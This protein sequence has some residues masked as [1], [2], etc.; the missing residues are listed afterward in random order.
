MG[1][2]KSKPTNSADN[3]DGHHHDNEDAQTTEMMN[4]F[5]EDCNCDGDPSQFSLSSPQ[6][7]PELKHGFTFRKDTTTEM[8]SHRN[9]DGVEDFDEEIAS[10][11]ITLSNLHPS[12]R[13]SSGP[14]QTLRETGWVGGLVSS[15][16]ARLSNLGRST[17]SSLDFSIIHGERRQNQN[18]EA[19]EVPA[20][21]DNETDDDVLA[22]LRSILAS[23][24][25]LNASM[26]HH[27]WRKKTKPKPRGC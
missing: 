13:T 14:D 17:S 3:K 22:L 2:G 10:S 12:R 11:D 26:R 21:N 25:N 16:S 27:P 19:V 7:T 9:D 20:E 4:S 24:E 18:Q 23:I 8:T 5:D 6:N 15:G 1:A